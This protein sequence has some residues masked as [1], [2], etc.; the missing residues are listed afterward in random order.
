MKVQQLSNQSVTVLLM[1][2]IDTLQKFTSRFL[3]SQS[4]VRTH[5]LYLN[6]YLLLNDSYF[7]F[8]LKHHKGCIIGNNGDNHKALLKCTNCRITAIQDEDIEH[9]VEITA[10]SFKMLEE[11]AKC[12]LQHLI[13]GL[14]HFLNEDLR[15]KCYFEFVDIHEHSQRNQREDVP[16]VNQITTNRW[17]PTTKGCS[18]P[19]GS[20]HKFVGNPNDYHWRVILPLPRDAF[21]GEQSQYSSSSL[22]YS[23]ASHNFFFTKSF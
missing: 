10:D 12:V 16:P 18:P 1:K 2:K 13:M 22:Y 14:D 6:H 4:L 15:R 23:N 9:A 17:S 7:Q 5:R 19:K 21:K 11:G 8:S 20:P 3:G